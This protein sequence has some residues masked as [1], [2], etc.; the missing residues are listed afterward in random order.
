MANMRKSTNK[1]IA[2][3]TSMMMLATTFIGSMNEIYAGTP[4]GSSEAT[5]IHAPGD[6]KAK[7]TYSGQAYIDRDGDLS[8]LDTAKGDEPKENVKIYLQW[9]NGK[10]VISPIYYTLSGADGKFCFDLSKP[11]KNALGEEYPFKLAGDDKFVVR[12]WVENPDPDKYTIARSGDAF[13]GTFHSRLKRVS[14][15]WDFTAGINRIVNSKVV[16][17]ERPNI[18]GWLAK[19]EAEWQKPTP[20]D[21]QWPNQKELYGTFRGS[22]WFD[23]T[24]MG[25]TL[26]NQ[27]YQ[28]KGD[29]AA[30]GKKVVASY[31][32][33]EVAR[34]FDKWKADNKNYTRQAFKEAQKKIVND[35]EQA[36]GKGSAI[37]ETVVANVDDKG[38]Y[39]IPF[40]G[41]YG[42]D[43]NKKGSGKVTDAQY[44]KLVEDADV[45]HDKLLTWNGTLGQV[46]RHINSD[47]M[48]AYPIIE[49]HQREIW[50]ASFQ[51]NMF[52]EIEKPAL[53]LEGANIS[54]NKFTLIS[55]R[56]IHNDLVYD[57]Q[58]NLAYAGVKVDNET[59]GLNPNKEFQI[60]WFKDGEKYG[61]PITLKSDD[62]GKLPSAPITVPNDLKRNTIFTSLVYPAGV[63]TND[64]ATAMCGD[65]F[66]A[67]VPDDF[68]YE[69]V[70][71]AGGKEAKTSSPTGDSR[72][73][74][75][76]VEKNKIP[77]NS[78]FELNPGYTI[79]TGYDISVDKNTGVVTVK[80]PADAADTTLEVPILMNV[81]LT[82]ADGT[83]ALDSDG[84]QVFVK[85]VLKAKFK[86]EKGAGTVDNEPPSAPNVK[87]EADGSVV[88]TPPSEPDT[89]KVEVKYTPEGATDPITVVA[90]KGNDG[91]WKLPQGTDLTINEDTGVITVPAD[92]VKDGSTV[93]AKATDESGNVSKEGSAKAKGKVLAAPNKPNKTEVGNPNK[94]TDDEKREGKTSNRR[95][96]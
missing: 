86:V 89:K 3:V 79:P 52:Q 77:A 63:D 74:D 23:N 12:T 26:E 47:Y 80:A 33:D 24:A 6:P 31:V 59:T 35:Y 39:Y 54:N 8:D 5:A 91:K 21:G 72:A 65:S 66:L 19:P 50:M 57:T 29:V 16:L 76:V 48:Y 46:L 85:Q 53:E 36:N 88:V 7:Q 58:E 71:V 28:E 64:M 32:N 81:A 30:T 78:T 84:K 25:G 4:Q 94:L 93:S 68:T 75:T 18:E 10:G 67:I 9:M 11:V 92:K 70:K 96:Q 69:E 38:E 55:P 27:Y 82:K 62:N 43:R 2:V 17:E 34:Q 95:C 56:P 15:S 14:E 20:E 22:M 61:E 37:A 45:N 87:A 51:D 60:Q 49:N 73:T 40:K 42:R 41:L 44:G 83:P 13:P 1:L 90:E